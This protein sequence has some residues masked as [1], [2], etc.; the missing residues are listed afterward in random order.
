MAL[1]STVA[2]L[3]VLWV[4][5]T[6][7]YTRRYTHTVSSTRMAMPKLLS[8]YSYMLI[9]EGLVEAE[10]TKGSTWISKDTR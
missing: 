2:T 3:I 5:T 8:E 4:P 10:D 1:D 9:V 6:G 7:S